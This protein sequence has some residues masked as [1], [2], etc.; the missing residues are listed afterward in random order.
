MGS[1]SFANAFFASLTLL[2][3]GPTPETAGDEYSFFQ[4]VMNSPPVVKALVVVLVVMSLI[5]WFIVGAKAVRVLQA[6]SH[7]KRFLAKFWAEEKTGGGWGAE[8]LEGLYAQVKQHDGSPLA[9][10]YHAGYVELARLSQGATSKE[11]L[12]ENV[13]RALKRAATVEMTKLESML[14]FLATTGS[15]AP[16][17]GL[18]GTV[19]GILEVFQ[20]IGGTGDASL[21]VVGPKIA[22]ALFVTAI[23]LF[24]AIPAVMAYN[25]F[26][27]RIRVIESEVETFA[28]DYL[29]I[30]KRHFL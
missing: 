7:T 15:T 5:S 22:E 24:A 26:L 12:L 17:I 20:R 11:G 23:G 8:R 16:F 25:T 28:S 13:E 18:L 14:P 2:Q 19:L 9:K 1:S 29:N 30:V 6:S 3:S 27:R 4:L 10:V 21:D